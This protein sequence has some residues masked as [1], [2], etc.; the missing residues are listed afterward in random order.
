MFTILPA[1]EQKTAALAQR[2]GVCMPVSAMVLTVDDTETGYALFTIQ[3]DC[4]TVACLY[5]P[6]EAW[7][8]WVLRA[9]LN[10]AANRGAVDA[11]FSDAAWFPLVK[12]LGFAS[13]NGEYTVFIPDFFNRPCHS[14]QK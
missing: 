13:C 14:N 2:E 8:E 5:A 7:A 11:R 12:R 9:V 3:R 6:D 4:V 10:A 1:D